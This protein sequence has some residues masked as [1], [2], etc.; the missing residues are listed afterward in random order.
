MDV[1]E[2]VGFDWDDGHSRQSSD[3]HSMN[4]AEAE[5]VSPTRAS[6]LR[7]TKSK[8]RR[9]ARVGSNKLRPAASAELHCSREQ[10]QNSNDFRP[11]GKPQRE[12]D[13]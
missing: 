6:L 10:H 11:R 3:K 5:Q 1:S 9:S 8:V 13:L 4:Q 7:Q 12:I 2:I